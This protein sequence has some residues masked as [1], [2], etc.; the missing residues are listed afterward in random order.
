MPTG[1]DEQRELLRRV[2]VVANLDRV[3][4]ARLVTHL[5]PLVVGSG[6]AVCEQGDPAEALFIVASGTFGVFAHDGGGERRLNTLGPGDHFG[7][8][9]LLTDDT[10]SATVRADIDGE[11]LRLDRETFLR[12]LDDDPQVG[13]AV[14][15]AL[16]RRLRQRDPSASAAVTRPPSSVIAATRGAGLR[17]AGAHRVVTALGV[18]AAAAIVGAAFFLVDLAQWRFS[19]L[20]LAAV[21]LW[22][23]EPVPT[24]V[25]SLGLV[26]A[27]VF[28][29]LAPDYKTVSGF[30][31]MSWVFVFAVLG[32]AGAV[33]RSGLLMRL[34][35][36]LIERVP[37]G[38]WWQSSAFVVTGILLTP[39]LPLAMARAAVT[40]PLS[41]AVADVL[42]LRDRSPAAAM[43]G[44]S[45]WTGSGPFLF[46][47]LNGSPVCLMAWSLMPLPAQEKFSWLFWVASAAPLAILIATGML[48]ALYLLDRPG[49]LGTPHREPLL[50][51]RAVLGPLSRNEITVA[52]IVA[53]MLVGFVIGPVFLIKPGLIA[54]GAFLAVTIATRSGPGDLARLDW[55]YLIFYGVALSLADIAT[56][57]RLDLIV[58]EGIA[59]RLTDIGIAGPVFVLLVGVTTVLVRS[60]LPADQAILLLSL[61]FIPVATGIGVHPWL[62]V[63]AILALGLSWHVPAQTPEFLVAQAASEGRLYSTMQARRASFAYIGV[64]L[65]SLAL[66][67]PYWHLLG[68]L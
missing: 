16:A 32:I 29:G 48:V 12:L 36:L 40:A 6:A 54:L 10:R 57:L 26:I 37:A 50:L 42:R 33:A 25:V 64:G 4:L 28:T 59:A 39:L 23:T 55:S 7:E 47:F 30:A 27:W 15:A 66:C 65:A 8:M 51:Q 17:R 41:L 44:L 60:F 11:V 24:Y 20:L 43:L 68:L 34:G 19:L 46:L 38:L 21:I 45:A 52:V 14:A 49:R 67:L 31:S 1:P 62:A 56:G 2:E 58:G 63:I 9:A 18:L 35:L 5:D 3:T 53:L 22:V 61:A 13:R